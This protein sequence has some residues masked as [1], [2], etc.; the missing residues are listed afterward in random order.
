MASRCLNKAMLIGNLTRDPEL[1]YT[2]SGTAVAT[3]GLATNRRWKTQGGDTKDEAQFHRVVVWNKL[4]ELCSQL[5]QKG[6]RVYIEGR[7]QYREWNDNEG[8]PR[9]T[10]EIVA[11]DMIVLDRSKNGDFEGDVSEAKNNEG[12]YDNVPAGEDQETVK[13]AKEEEKD[14][15]EQGEEEMPF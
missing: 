4:A 1:R 15:E 6:S 3:F 12:E 8:N 5:I 10:T 7:I 2:P 13:P 9:Q 11:E 14:T